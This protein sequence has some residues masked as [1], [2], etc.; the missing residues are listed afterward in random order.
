MLLYYNNKGG[1]LMLSS[2]APPTCYISCVYAGGKRHLAA[3]PT[4][5]ETSGDMQWSRLNDDGGRPHSKAAFSVMSAPAGRRRAFGVIYLWCFPVT[6]HAAFD[7]KTTALSASIRTIHHLKPHFPRLKINLPYIDCWQRCDTGP[8]S[9]V[10]W[11]SLLTF[12]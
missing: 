8:R 9:I 12:V 7:G 3:P 11:H 5:G 6:S 1:T 2:P 4:V 10:G